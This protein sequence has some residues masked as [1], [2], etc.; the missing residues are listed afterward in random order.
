MRYGL[1]RSE[2]KNYRER[3]GEFMIQIVALDDIE[4]HEKTTDYE[5]NILPVMSVNKFTDINGEEIQRLVGHKT[6]I[7]CILRGVPHAKAQDIARIVKTNEFD[8]TYTTPLAITNKFRCTKYNAV[9]KCS[10]PRQKNPLV[11]DKI[12]WN[13]SLTLESAS[14]A[15]DGDGL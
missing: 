13:I 15:A 8:L 4:I 9:P 5:I 10:D 12:T 2:C 14:I 7:S 6:T 1:S 11:T 3:I